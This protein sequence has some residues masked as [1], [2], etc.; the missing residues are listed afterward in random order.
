MLVNLRGNSGSGKS[1]IV[2]AIMKKAI[3]EGLDRDSKMRPR[4]YRVVLKGFKKHLFVIGRYETQCGG[5]DTISSTAELFARVDKYAKQG[6]VLFEGLLI[7]SYWGSFG[8]WA[9]KYKGRIVFA[10]LD[11]PLEEC[12]AR[13]TQRRIVAG[14]IKPFNETNTRRRAASIEATKARAIADGQRIVTISG[15]GQSEKAVLGLFE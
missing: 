10:Y 9:K 7:S 8:E 3:V 13:V 4:N 6:H 5:V 11:T 14:N 1:T 12:L 15:K 2:R